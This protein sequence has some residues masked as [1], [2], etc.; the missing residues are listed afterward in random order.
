MGSL[1]DGRKEGVLGRGAGEPDRRRLGD[2][3]GFKVD[4]GLSRRSVEEVEALLS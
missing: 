4:A 3:G 1:L 2:L